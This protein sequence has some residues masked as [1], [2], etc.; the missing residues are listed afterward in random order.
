MRIGNFSLRLCSIEFLVR[1]KSLQISSNY[2]KIPKLGKFLHHIPPLSY[3][4][5][6]NLLFNPDILVIGGGIVGLSA[7]LHSNMRFPEAK[8]LVLER[9]LLPM[10]ASTKNAGFACFGSAGE[11]L[12]DLATQ[13]ESAVFDL[14]KNRFD[15]LTLLRQTLGD[16][17]IEFD[18]CG[19]FELFSSTESLHFSHCHQSLAYLNQQLQ[20]ITGHMDTYSQVDEKIASFGFK[21]TTHMLFNRY[22]GS[23]HTGKAM[24]ALW[25]KCIEQGIMVLNGMDCK[26]L[27]SV[28]NGTKVE[29][30]S[31]HHLFAAKTILATNAFAVQLLPELEVKPGRAQVLITDPI[32]NLPF[33]GTFH[34]DRGYFY[35][36]NVGHRVLFGGGRNLDFEGETSFDFQT[37]SRI[38]QQLETYLREMILPGKNFQIEQR[39]SGI[40][41][42]GPNR[43]S[44]LKKLD[45]HVIVAVRMGGM[46]VA[47]GS[48]I[49]KKA[50]EML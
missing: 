31:G 50:A 28:S 27:V 46:G 39:W 19:G 45:E 26:A 14:V 40:M 1:L 3:W 29:L 47:L 7:A 15:G 38:Q 23:I 36:R 4:E 20:G 41:G 48:L 8:I 35:F 17:V 2:N 12:D 18:P 24:V 25:K 13:P 10:G 9:G 5:S 22:E 43:S 6:Q 11:L 30:H 33:S 34:F 42:L 16:S 32:E 21:Q 37:T 44:I 49:G